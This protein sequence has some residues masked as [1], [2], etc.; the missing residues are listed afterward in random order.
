MVIMIIGGGLITRGLSPAG[1]W[2]HILEF[3]ELPP[4]GFLFLDSGSNHP[5]GP[6]TVPL[7]E[8]IVMSVVVGARP[9]AHLV[10]GFK[11]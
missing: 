2:L 5:G 8:N 4:L 1:V 6:Q 7:R 11:S 3:N 9:C 10:F